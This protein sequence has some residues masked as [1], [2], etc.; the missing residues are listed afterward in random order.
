MQPRPLGRSGLSIAPLMLGGNVFGWSA[1]ET[2]SHRLLDAFVDAGFNAIDTADSYSRWVPG[3]K[4]GES[5]TIIGHWLKTS[6]KRRKVVIATKVGSDMGQGKCLKKDH[7]LRSADQSLKRLQIDTIDLYQSHF[8]DEVTPVEETLEAYAQLIK[9]GKVR[10]IGA[11]NLSPA[12]L[13]ASFEA[14]RTHGLPRYET[15]QP[16]Y[17]LYDRAV[18]EKDY[19]PIATAEKIGV[20]PYYSL[21]SGFLTGKYKSKED[22]EKSPTRGGKVENYFDARGVAI[23]K[24]LDEMAGAKSATPAQVALAWLMARPSITAP[25]AS[26]TKPDQ[27]ADILGAA[28]LSLTKDEVT[29]LD[30]ASAY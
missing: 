25:I 4:G 13:K 29:A 23:L 19:E 11:S 21:A 17:N 10:A 16:N 1:D 30:K 15:L 5:E 6:G 28:K 12:R 9:A 7:I 2:M 18:Y 24:A 20:I 14:S 22:A 3:H 27:L 8:D 26:A